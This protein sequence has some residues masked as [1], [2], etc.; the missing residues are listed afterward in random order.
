MA[1]KIDPKYQGVWV[2]EDDEVAPKD[3][4]I[5]F[6]ESTFDRHHGGTHGSYSSLTVNVNS[7]VLDTPIGE[8]VL[9]DDQSGA[10][11]EKTGT[12]PKVGVINQKGKPNPSKS[13][14]KGDKS[15]NTAM[16]LILGLAIVGLFGFNKVF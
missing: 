9:R 14:S 6:K 7:V 8:I 4:T 3:S 1:H 13:D 12:P 11:T 5:E 15:D 10:I 16:A 2:F